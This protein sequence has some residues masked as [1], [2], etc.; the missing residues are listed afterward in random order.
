MDA[1]TQ[2]L[3]SPAYVKKT[4]IFLSSTKWVL[5]IVMWV[6][7][8]FW[9][10]LIFLFPAEPVNELFEKWL[11]LSSGTVFGITGW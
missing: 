7:F 5:K 9:A 2:P 1:P 8:I 3:L 6:I 11:Q 4:P 10:T